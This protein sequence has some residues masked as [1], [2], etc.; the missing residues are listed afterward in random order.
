MYS[1][2]PC[3]PL[4]SS[5]PSE[6]SSPLSKSG[7]L[8]LKAPPGGI[9]DSSVARS[10]PLLSTLHTVGLM[11]KELES[12]GGE[13]SWS[14]TSWALKRPCP[15]SAFPGP[16]SLPARI[17]HILSPFLSLSRGQWQP[18][19]SEDYVSNRCA[20]TDKTWVRLGSWATPPP[21]PSLQA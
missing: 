10:S 3:S 2:P 6:L 7:S 13:W 9:S 4:L 20:S 19:E 1:H 14:A 17:L 5:L 18:E 11:R 8:A 12:S 16:G 15:P 21:L